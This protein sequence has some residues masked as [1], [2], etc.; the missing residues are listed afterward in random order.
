MGT[1]LLSACIF[2]ASL[3]FRTDLPPLSGPSGEFG[4]GYATI[5]RQDDSSSVFRNDESDL[6][7]KLALL[8][9]RL[10]TPAGEG[11]GAGTPA[12]EGRF[13]LSV[14]DAHDEA[15]QTGAVPGR[16]I[17]SGTGRY[18]N[19]AAL[20]RHPLGV[21][22]SLEIGV[23]QRLNK[24]TDLLNLGGSLYQYSEQRS[25]LAQRVDGSIGWRHRW[26]G[27]EMAG[28]LLAVRPESQYNTAY[29]FRRSRAW[30]PGA[31]LE[32]RLRRG[33]WVLTADAERTSGSMT[34]HEQSAPDFAHVAYGSHGVF[35]AAGLTLERDGPSTQILLSATLDRSRLPFV[36][37]AVL[38]EETRAFDQGR[39][40]FSRTQEW[41]WDLQARHRIA[42]GIHLRA[43]IRVIEG[44]ET[45]R[46]VDP[47]AAQ[48]D[49]VI[50]VRRGGRLPVTQFLLGGGADFSIGAASDP[51]R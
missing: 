46:L 13:R 19:F 18:E 34:V 10:S 2:C 12:R 5:S 25:L 47:S 50:P 36:A 44:N 20:Y 8:G 35:E 28:A 41:I 11:L 27:I 49:Q 22:D 14:G 45:V 43:Y 38:G 29:S 4:A 33:R 15:D 51:G 39:R 3:L 24:N 17:S 42:P 23:E 7:G 21:A 32:G 48:P 30:L 40:P 37:V 16:V 31:S 26:A 6:T 1:D 9:M